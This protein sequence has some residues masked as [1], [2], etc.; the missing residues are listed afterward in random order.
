MTS[1]RA[2]LIGAASLV[3]TGRGGAQPRIYRIGYLSASSA[4]ANAP[5][6]MAFSRG[7]EELGYRVGRDVAVEYRFADGRFDRLPGL[8]AKSSRSSRTSCL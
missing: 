8:A 5:N 1:R 2:I 7:L 6:R 3:M 4:A